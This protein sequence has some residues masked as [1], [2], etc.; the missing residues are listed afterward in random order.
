M[1]GTKACTRE[2]SG[3][4]RVCSQSHCGCL[5]EHRTSRVSQDNASPLTWMVSVTWE[6]FTVSCED[7]GP[8]THHCSPRASTPKPLCISRP[9]TSKA[10]LEGWVGGSIP[11][12]AIPRR[13]DPSHT[14][15]MTDCICVFLAERSQASSQ[16]PPVWGPGWRSCQN[17][18]SAPGPN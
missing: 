4:P 8:W 13:A 7:S 16:L 1:D 9:W 15:P 2:G 6:V 3:V 5:Q 11:L 10:G 18:S 14:S 12:G 17:G